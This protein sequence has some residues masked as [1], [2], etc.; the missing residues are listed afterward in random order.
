MLDV[1]LVKQ[2]VESHG[3]KYRWLYAYLGLGH[4]TGRLMIREGMLLKDTARNQEVLKKLAELLGHQSQYEHFTKQSSES[5]VIRDYKAGAA[6]Y[7]GNREDSLS[8]Y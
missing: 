5:S 4:S 2:K 1:Q 8:L 6:K 7:F 3:I